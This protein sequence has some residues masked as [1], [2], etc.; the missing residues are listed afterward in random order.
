M[1]EVK[2]EN[3]TH[4]TVL[5]KTELPSGDLD[6]M[7]DAIAKLLAP[8]D[9]NK[10]M[11]RYK[12]FLDADDIKRMAEHYKVDM[13]QPM[14]DA[15][16]QLLPHMKDWDG[17]EG[18]IDMVDGTPK[19]FRWST[20]NP[21]SKWDWYSVGGRWQG[22]L[23]LHVGKM[24]R[25]GEHGVFDRN[26]PLVN[27]DVAFLKDVD[28][29]GMRK[30]AQAEAIESYYKAVEWLIGQLE[31]GQDL[32]KCIGT[33]YWEYDLEDETFEEYVARHGGFSTH[34]VVDADG[35]HEWSPMGWWG[36]HGKENE[37]ESEWATKFAE[38]W[39]S[40]ATDKTAIA[41][42]DCHI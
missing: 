29:D 2:T 32:D 11:P 30:K 28:F 17:D 4:F 19:M 42:V 6:D 34:A 38:R 22:H 33:L 8:Y 37:A 15:L 24:G 41:L 31:S 14:M 12:V 27:A 23:T 9:E 25:Q 13:A 21:D 26:A 35:W 40:N 3:M 36:C 10:E 20:Y 1:K 16:N 18:G 7:D 5:V 39:L